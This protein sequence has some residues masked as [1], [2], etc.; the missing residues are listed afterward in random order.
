M[1]RVSRGEWQTD[2]AFFATIMSLCA[3]ASA[4][5]RDGA[6]YSGRWNVK[7]LSEPA[8]DVFFAAAESAL[9]KDTA[10][11]EEL[12]YLRA[13]AFLTLAALQNSQVTKMHYYLGYYGMLIK[14]RMLHDEKYWSSPLTIIQKEERRRLVCRSTWF[15][16]LYTD[17][18]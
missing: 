17:K 2:R 10:A 13:C 11:A 5:V 1:T 16:L 12:D 18:S 9:P 4:R 7:M 6:L 14:C 8:S 3:L 15:A